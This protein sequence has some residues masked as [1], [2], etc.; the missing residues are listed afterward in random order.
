[1]INCNA[2]LS[3]ES[4]ILGSKILFEHKSEFEYCLLNTNYILSVKM[5]RDYSKLGLRESKELIDLYKAGKLIPDPDIKKERV[6]KL[7]RLKKIPFVNELTDK[8]TSLN[9]YNLNNILNNLSFKELII[10]D[11]I[12]EKEISKTF[13][14]I[15][16]I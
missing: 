2:F 11:E 16:T 5:M 12:I 13:E 3:D 9:S 10:I 15:I 14:K 4:L 7:K 6:D 8:I 1:M